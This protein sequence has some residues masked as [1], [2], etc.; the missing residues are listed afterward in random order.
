MTEA[1]EAAEAAEAASD[2]RALDPVCGM[3][4]RRDGPHRWAHRGTLYYFCNPRCLARFQAEPERYLAAAAAPKAAAAP[5]ADTRTYTCPMHPEVRKQGPGTCPKC[6]MALEPL[7][8]SAEPEENPEL[9]DM[10]RR[11]KWSA[12]LTLPVVA[13]TMGEM[14]PGWPIP[15]DFPIAWIQAM[16]ATPIVLWGG[17]PFFER[18]WASLR[19]L[20]PNMFTLIAL[21]TG[22]AWLQ[23]T[24]AVLAPSLFPDSF[25]DA[26]GRVA[27]YFEAATVIVTLVLLGQ[28]LELGARQR[29]GEAIRA[30]LRLAPKTAR[31][32]T[33]AGEEDVPLE[34]VAPGDRLRVRPGENV[35]V[36]GVVLEGQSAIDES[37]ITGEPMPVAA[38]AGS[39]VTGGT[40]NG[41]GTFVMRA[42]QVGRDTLLARIVALVAEA[43]RSRAPS[44][45]LADAVSAWFVPAVVLVALVAFAAWSLFGP[46]PRFAH[47]LVA[48]VSVL[49]IACPCALGLATPMSILVATGR[50]AHAGVMF[51]DAEAIVALAQIDTLLVD[52]TGTL[53]QGKPALVSLVPAAGAS[54]GE[55]LR[56]AAALERGSE[57]PLAAAVLA[58]ASARGIDAPAAEAFHARTGRGVIGHLDGA[59]VALG[60]GTLMRELGI[61]IAELRA[62]AE[63]RR[64]EGQTVMFAAR[65]G[66]LLGLL[67][68]A[69]PI[70]PTAGEAVAALQADGVRLVLIS[71][72]QRATAEF[73]AKQLGIA[74]VVAEV[75]PEQKLAVLRE[76]Q[77]RGSVVAMAG[78]GVNDAPALAAATVGIAMGTGT[79]VAMS[80]AGVTLVAGD[81]RG[82]VRA[83]H[84]S[85][86]TRQNIRQ[87]LFF[88]FAY[89]ALGV[90]L[91]AGVLYPLTGALLSPM[92]AA[93]AMSLSSVSVIGNALRLRRAA[94]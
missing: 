43:Q 10:L 59:D 85:R 75:L 72:D 90:P 63:E 65:A 46:E 19:P 39:H 42:Q 8:I 5:S 48:A 69:D 35:P 77:R 44:Q 92:I 23:S 26:H 18:A 30:L 71:G 22:A 55:L 58:G 68:V 74:E 64:R 54:E 78:D 41:A 91:A 45:R 28:V 16:L 11:F 93:A 70:K 62:P 60:N 21:G 53:T 34:V 57:H 89:N 1:R 51:R 86:A 17:K 37:M 36:D 80:S 6:G 38:M 61:E 3:S 82:L 2:E 81:L 67:G 32:V 52:K 7:E 33:D 49:I 73:V 83:R 79:D 56:V 88:A 4:V 40:L 94:L 47:A 24:I 50:G 13:L 12:V 76:R 9:R 25:R 20:H 66:R 27:V 15:H 29:T 84:L 87:N 14:L 31:R